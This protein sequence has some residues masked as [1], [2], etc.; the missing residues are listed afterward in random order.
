MY[1]NK[2]SIIILIIAFLSLGAFLAPPLIVGTP[3]M[4]PY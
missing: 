1:K 2:I 3:S 4:I